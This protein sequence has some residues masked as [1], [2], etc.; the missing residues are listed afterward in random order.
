M[1][2]FM[3]KQ[4]WKSVSALV[5]VLAMVCTS[6]TLPNSAQAAKKATLKTKKITVTVGKKKTITLKNKK[7]GAKYTFK[8]KKASIAKVSS[9]GVVTGKKA[10]ST[11]VTVTEKVKKKSRKVGVVKVT[12]KKKTTSNT[13]VQATPEPIVT[14]EPV[15]TPTPEPTVTPTPE[16]T[17][18]TPYGESLSKSVISTGNNARV[19]SVIEKA[20]AGE[21]VT[22]AY[23]GGSIT[24]GALAKPNSNCYAETSAKL[25]GEKYGK[26]GGAKVHFVN[27]GMSG[28]PSSIG[29]VR[30]ERDVLGQMTVGDHP[31]I[32]FIEFA[33]NDNGECTKG[34]AYEGLI[35]RGLESGAAVVLVF[36]IFNHGN[37]NRV[38]ESDYKPYGKH[39]DLPM[40]SMGDAIQYR[41][42]ED[43]FLKWYYGDTLHPSNDGHRMMAD[44]I[45]ELMDR[46]DKEEAETINE[47]PAAKNTDA[48]TNM[49]FLSRESVVDSV[50]TNIDAGSFSKKDSNT[51][52]FQYTYKGKKNAS[53]FPENWMHGTS[54]G[55]DS[56]KA[57][58]TCK[59]LMVLYKLTSNTNAGKAEI[60]VD[61]T[62]I[63]TINS[64]DTSGW[65]NATNAIVFSETSAKSHNIEVKMASGDENKT[66][67]LLGFGYSD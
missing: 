29:I 40:I 15:V 63:K 35:R 26:D 45:M 62:K 16:P 50:I 41:F 23:I 17:P 48:Y 43:G 55:T 31:D 22:L 60:W 46:I 4:L 59:T 42:K 8:V 27:A 14:P 6:V 18:L 47:I 10:G 24:E 3:K 37:G 61:G 38:C 65:N 64:Y 30:Y 7:K 49:K 52:N 54:S 67:T 51:C 21:D 56:F 36:S 58:V 39:Y 12:V 57:T 32:L 28:T 2:D 66:F 33:V 11:T 44:C 5:L 19:K 9:K 25:F 20:R 1:E 13:N 34:G 53:W